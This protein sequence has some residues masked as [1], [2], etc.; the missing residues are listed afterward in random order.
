MTTRHI[1]TM[2]EIV[3]QIIVLS[4]HTDD[5]DERDT[6]TAMLKAAEP[7]IARQARIEAATERV[8][9]HLATEEQEAS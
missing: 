5:Q 6:L 9:L 1:P 7:H 3:D 4:E 2:H 8:I